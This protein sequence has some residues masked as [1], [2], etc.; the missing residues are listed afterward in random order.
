MKAEDRKQQPEGKTIATALAEAK[1]Q[2]KSFSG[3]IVKTLLVVALIILLILPFQMFW[4]WGSRENSD[5]WVRL[6]M[7]SDAVLAELIAKDGDTLPGQIAR[8]YE[9]RIDFGPNGLDLITSQT[10]ATRKAAIASIEKARMQYLKLA[11]ELKDHPMFRYEA[12]LNAARA[13]ETLIGIP[14]ADKSSE[15]R[16]DVTLAQTLYQQAASVRSAIEASTK[17][18]PQ[19]EASIAINANFNQLAVDPAA[20]A[21]YLKDHATEAKAFYVALNDY[22]AKRERS[23]VPA[24][25]VFPGIGSN[26]GD[27]PFG[28]IMMPEPITPGTKTTPPLIAP[29]PMVPPLVV[30]PAPA[31]KAEPKV[32][33]TPTAPVTA[34]APAAPEKK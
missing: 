24:S 34:P 13:E 4:G 3:W 1:G 31:T 25:P 10:P 30:P 6:D 8:I 21:A 9:A 16:G 33:P 28:P 7:A 20:K 23:E 22:L 27:N 11:D 19:S 29:T 18:T 32:E 15:F 26:P 2:L 12:Y 17:A 5:R 14:K